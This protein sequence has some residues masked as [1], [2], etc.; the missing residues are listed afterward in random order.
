MDYLGAE[1][2]DRGAQNGKIERS[3]AHKKAIK[4]E[5][6]PPPNFMKIMYRYMLVYVDKRRSIR[7]NRNWR[8]I[9]IHIH[10]CVYT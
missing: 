8:N 10:I 5:P 6:R 7:Y 9:H 2:G 1:D 3:D 4:A